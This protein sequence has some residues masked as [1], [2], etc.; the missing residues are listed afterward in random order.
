MGSAGGSTRGSFG[1]A[2][3]TVMSASIDCPMGSAESADRPDGRSIATTVMPEALTSA[4]TVST[5]PE[6]GAFSPVPKIASTIAC[7]RATS[8]GA[9]PRPPLSR[10]FD[11]RDAQAAE[12]LEVDPGIAAHVGDLSDAGTRHVDI[13]LRERS[14][15]DEAVAAVV[16]A[17]R[18]DD[19]AP[20]DEV[21]V[22]GLDGRDHL[23]AGVLHQHQRRNADLVDGPAVGFPH[24]GGGENAH[25][26]SE[27]LA[28]SLTSR[29]AHEDGRERGDVVTMD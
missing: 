16:A 12:D 11:D 2:S 25:K 5:R 18:E 13:A 10:D 29:Y 22:K 6:T 26:K 9:A 23:P 8:R 14:R 20:V 3:V 4:M 7:S 17:A 19:D 27:C 1:A 21:G 28:R 15:D 24:L